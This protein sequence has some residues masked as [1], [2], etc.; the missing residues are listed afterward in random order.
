MF[1][2]DLALAYIVPVPPYLLLFTEAATFPFRAL[3]L[4]VTLLALKPIFNYTIK[5]K[6]KVFCFYQLI[7]MLSKNI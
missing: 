1:D 7:M 4:A 5:E 3:V 2:L 6:S